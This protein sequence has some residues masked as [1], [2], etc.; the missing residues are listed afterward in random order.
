MGGMVN[1]VEAGY[2]QNEIMRAS[3]EFQRAVEDG[4]KVI[5]GVNRFIAK[6]EHPLK[7]LKIDESVERAQVA[8]ILDTKKNRD[9]AKVAACLARIRDTARSEANLMDPILEAV[10][11]YAMLGEICG[12]L[13]DVFGAYQDPAKF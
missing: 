8:R 3:M 13:M 9:N 2:P 11:E 10:R 1:A 6:E 12:A 7:L 4:R 5:V